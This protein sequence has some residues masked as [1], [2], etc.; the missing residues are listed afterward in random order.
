MKLYKLA[1]L[2]LAFCSYTIISSFDLKTGTAVSGGK[3][4]WCE[5]IITRGALDSITGMGL[6]TLYFFSDY[7]KQFLAKDAI[8]LTA[9]STHD[10]TQ[11]SKTKN[12][13]IEAQ[14]G[15]EFGIKVK[16]DQE[17]SV[18]EISKFQI[19]SILALPACSSAVYF[20]L[21][22][23]SSG[24]DILYDIIPATATKAPFTV[25]IYDIQQKSKRMYALNFLPPSRNLSAG[26]NELNTEIFD[27]F[28][29]TADMVVGTLHPSPPADLDG[30]N[31]PSL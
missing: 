6:Q 8:L 10:S 27:Q 24:L 29:V 21:R 3:L 14:I 11:P 1:M 25:G 9:I 18:Y 26:W 17:F 7:K 30:E 19:D 23:R 13:T 31:G 16:K 28:K 2:L 4:R 20:I 5:M 12:F 15:K 22:P